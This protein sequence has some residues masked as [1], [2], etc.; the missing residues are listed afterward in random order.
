MF[1]L[2]RPNF[3]TLFPDKQFL[4]VDEAQDMNPTTLAIVGYQR[5]LPKMVVGDPNQQI[6]QFR[7]SKNALDTFRHCKTFY[8]TQSFRFGSEIAYFADTWLRTM[9]RGKKQFLVSVFLTCWFKFY[10]ILKH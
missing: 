3:E 5:H 1:Q 2:S 7:G 10:V 6:Y 8:L 9:T 4:M